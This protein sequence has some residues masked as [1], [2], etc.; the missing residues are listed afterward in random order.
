MRKQRG[1]E[2]ERWEA[3]TVRIVYSDGRG[4][5]A[6]RQLKGDLMMRD[7]RPGT[8]A[9]TQAETV[10]SLYDLQSLAVDVLTMIRLAAE[11][12]GAEQDAQHLDHV[13]NEVMMI[14]STIRLGSQQATSSKNEPVG[15]RP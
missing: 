13:A 2:P 11:D 7:D 6:L 9:V 10:P 15:G 14:C 5:C 12:L 3:S 1:P 4:R 8:V